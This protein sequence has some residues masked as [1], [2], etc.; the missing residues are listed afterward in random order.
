V[1]YWSR[2]FLSR[3]SNAE[4]LLRGSHQQER[5]ADLHTYDGVA[6][7]RKENLAVKIACDMIR[8]MCAM[9]SGN[10]DMK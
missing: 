10:R 4:D 8:G 2:V 7:N 5:A 6:G 1:F 3:G 9:E